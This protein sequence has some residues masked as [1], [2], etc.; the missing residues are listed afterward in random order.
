[1]PERRLESPDGLF[2][3]P[4]GRAGLEALRY[5]PKTIQSFPETVLASYCGVGNP[6]SLGPISRGEAVLDIGCGPGTASLACSAFFAN[7]PVS[8]TGV[9]QN[10]EILKDAKALEDAGVFS[11]V[12]EGVPMEL[13]KEITRALKIPTIGIGAGPHCDG[14]VLVVNDMLGLTQF[15]GKA[16]K[17]VK[18]YAELA[19]VVTRCVKDYI[20]DVEDGAFPAKEHSY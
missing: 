18:K 14:Q 1:M 16:P 13:A 6:F 2:T 17:Y 7:R 15:E 12:I 11:I 5:D 10:R 3:Y 9:D 8:I 19:G 20:K 4:T